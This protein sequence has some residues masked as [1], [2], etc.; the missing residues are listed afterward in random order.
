M[1][2]LSNKDYIKLGNQG[3]LLLLPVPFDT[4]VYTVDMNT[5]GDYEVFDW[6]FSAVTKEG[7][8]L[9]SQFSEIEFSR[10]EFLEKVYFEKEVADKKLM[11]LRSLEES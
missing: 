8:V 10:E 2:G 3:L 6:V 5:C 4:V 7:Y 11:E 9:T 1:R